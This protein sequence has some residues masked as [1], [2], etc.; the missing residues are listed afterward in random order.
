MSAAPAID[1]LALLGVPRDALPRHI[2]V[3]MDGNGRWAQLRG[4]Q[5]IEGHIHASGAVR[6]TISHC[7]QLGIECLTLY[8]F[9]VENWKRP[10]P[11]VEGLMQLYARSLAAERKELHEKNVRI[12][13]I[14]RAADLPPDVRRELEIS[15]EL[16]K[17]NTG[18]TLCIA[19]NYGARAEI[20]DAVRTLAARVQSGA[21][22][23]ED[24]DE[25]AF[26]AELTTAGIPDPDLIIRTAGEM[27]LSNFLLWQASYSEFFATPV[28]FPDFGVEPLNE[29]ILSFAR[30]ER[31]YGDVGSRGPAA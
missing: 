15:R 17:D 21:L 26:T 31:R 10:R 2:A 13:H 11:E 5:R 19:L 20:I 22:R 27:R 25:A 24:I 30:R 8:A 1:S 7:A 9:S 12:R 3:I 6:T 23:P 4:K 29:A 18:L 28:L 16:T 14:G